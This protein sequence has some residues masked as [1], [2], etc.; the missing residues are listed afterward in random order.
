MTSPIFCAWALRH[1]TTGRFMPYR[2]ARGHS[3]WEPTESADGEL[4]RLF[5]SERS[6][7]NA[8]T[9]WAH[10]PWEARRGRTADTVNGWGEDYEDIVPI[11]PQ[12]PRS[13]DDLEIV[14]V[15]VVAA[16]VLQLL[17][18]TAKAAT[19]MGYFGGVSPSTVENLANLAL[20]CMEPKP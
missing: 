7:I 8:R 5:F 14:K 16:G 6:A 2:E 20:S 17:T 19:Q 10:G 3:H 12:V 1:I 11:A 9:A 4:P 15:H 13:R 18:D